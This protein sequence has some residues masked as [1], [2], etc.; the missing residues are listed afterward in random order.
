LPRPLPAR[1]SGAGWK[2]AG[3]GGGRAGLCARGS[4]FA[5]GKNPGPGD[6]LKSF[7]K[8]ACFAGAKGKKR[9]FSAITVVKNAQK[10]P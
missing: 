9:A 8:T 4:F 7:E 1:R 6:F 5:G 2:P 3:R 10:R